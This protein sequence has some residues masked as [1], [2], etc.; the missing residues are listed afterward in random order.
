MLK[1]S[2]DTKICDYYKYKGIENISNSQTF[3]EYITDSE[4]EFNIGHVKLDNLTETEL[5]EYIKEL[6]Y[7]WEN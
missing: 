1:Y 7:L 4:N 2:L 3:R 6:D 5:E